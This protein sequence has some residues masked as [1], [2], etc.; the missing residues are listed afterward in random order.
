LVYSLKSQAVFPGLSTLEVLW[1]IKMQLDEVI[2]IR[3]NFD[4]YSRYS[5]DYTDIDAAPLAR[6]PANLMAAND[7][8]CALRNG[9]AF[10]NMLHSGEKAAKLALERLRKL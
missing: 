6:G 1:V 3:A 7:A 10:G 9:P 2:I 8:P 5:L 4:E